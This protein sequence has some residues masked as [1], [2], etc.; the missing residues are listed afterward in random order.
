VGSQLSAAVLAVSTIRSIGLV[1]MALVLIG[2]VVYVIANVRSGRHEVGA[3]IELAP[4]RKPY[5]DDEALEGRK[6]ERSLGWG[7]LTLAVVGL[8]LPLY[9][10]NEPGRMNGA[11]SDFS[12]VFAK[13]GEHLFATTA[14]GGYNCAG[15][16][17]P[18]GV[19][20]AYPYTITDPDGKFVAQVNWQAPA[21]NTVLLRYSKAEVTYI[22]TYGRPFSPMPAWGIAGGGPLNAQQIQN[23][24]DYLQ[25]IQLTSAA[26]KKAA[27]DELAKA[28]KMVG[29]DGKPLYASEGEALFN[30]G[31]DDGFAGGAY[32]CGRCH[33]Q[34]WSYYADANAPAGTKE[35]PNGSGALGP[36]LTG[37]DT[38]RQFPGTIKAMVDFV[39]LGSEDGKKYGVHGQGTGK[40]PG[41]GD[42]PDDK[43]DPKDDLPN[44]GMLTPEMIQMIVEYERSL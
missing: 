33:T 37:G 26:S 23:L 17:G 28:M 25:S 32:S 2:F 12:T 22:L 24:V 10:L 3:E 11:K 43:D 34:G 29:A 18:A 16:H 5:L 15:C 6:L 30:L 19:G 36:N 21:L 9:W 7:L 13:R 35:V 14:E 4:N 44:D 41:F 39:T 40:M 20:G 42:N 1:I 38:V 27:A 8:G 31:R